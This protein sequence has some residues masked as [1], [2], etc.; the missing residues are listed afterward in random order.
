MEV[1]ICQLCKEPIANFASL[2]NLGR[3]IEGWLPSPANER[4]AETNRQF[5]EIFRYHPHKIQQHHL[6]VNSPISESIC[7]YCYVN[8]VY[9]WLD[10]IDRAV[11]RRFRKLFAFGMK[12]E[13]FREVIL[14]H[15]EPIT[16]KMPMSREFGLCDVCGDFSEELS[17]SNGDWLCEGCT[18]E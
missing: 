10:G 13:E 8:A 4:F 18:G 6:V 12:K 14:S 15:A 11:A 5:L 1:Q 2:E 17:N 3:S 16:E 7:L 9:Q